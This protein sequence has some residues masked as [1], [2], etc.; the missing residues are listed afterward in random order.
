[1]VEQSVIHSQRLM[2]LCLMSLTSLTGC[3]V[4]HLA[5]HQG[6]LLTSRRPVTEAIADPTTPYPVKVR[7]ADLPAMIEFAKSCGLDPGNSYQRYIDNGDR[8]LSWLVHAAKPEKLEAKTWWFPFTGSV[9]YLGFFSKS[10]RDD[11]EA[12]L[13]AQG[14]DTAKGAATAFSMLGIIADPVYRSMTR[15]SRAEFAHVIFHELVHRTVWIKGS[16][17]FNERLAEVFARRVTLAWLD[18]V[19][20]DQ[21]SRQEFLV[22]IEDRRKFGVWLAA[23]RRELQALYR[24]PLAY[25]EILRRKAE[26]FADFTTNLQRRPKF[27]GGEFIVG[28]TWNNAEVL[29][30]GLYDGDDFPCP[31][32]PADPARAKAFMV[33]LVQNKNAEIATTETLHKV[34]L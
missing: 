29:A 28:R 17:D 30:S 1:M 34:C 20:A 26:I 9:P 31:P 25:E 13:K 5:W 15:R 33:W 24:L 19:G 10:E 11:E 3:Y 8:P 4:S 12:K 14:F 6:K 2:S 22:D 27:A 23:L 32:E 7:L 16:V 21:A 18:A